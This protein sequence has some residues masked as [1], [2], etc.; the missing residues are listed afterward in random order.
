MFIEQHN[1]TKEEILLTFIKSLNVQA[2]PC[3]RRRS[4]LIETTKDSYY[5]PFDPEARLNTEFNNRRHTS[6][7]GFTQSFI[8]AWDAEKKLFSFTISG[9]NFI[10]N[11]VEDINSFGELLI[12]SLAQQDAKY[13]TA[14]KIYANIKLEEIP[15]YDNP[16]GLVY[17]SWTLR[18][19]SSSYFAETELDKLKSGNMA[20]DINN[21][22]FSGLSFSTEPIAGEG[23]SLATSDKFIPAVEY[24]TFTTR[25]QHEYSL[26]ILTKE[27]GQWQLYE[28]ARLP[29]IE[30]G[31][32][33]DSIEVGHLNAKSIKYENHPVAVFDIK[34]VENDFYQLHLYEAIAKTS[35]QAE[36]LTAE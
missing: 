7:N 27:A 8:D 3:S 26:C 34:P 35:N 23:D 15:L 4:T 9:Y 16:N 20:G 1:H 32:I 25:P 24:E 11:Q 29:R 12:D 31:E 2:Y 36:A 18:N 22:Y 6:K 21:Y 13:L 33:E 19:Q 14:S 10:I 28:P 5:I 30:H 17:T